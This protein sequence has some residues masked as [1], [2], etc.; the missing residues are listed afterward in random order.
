MSA[1]RR[2]A[3][4]LLPEHATEI[5]KA[6][7]PYDLWISILMWFNAAYNAA[8]PGRIVKRIYEYLWWTRRQPRQ[9]SADS[10]LYTA[11]AC[12]FVEHIPDHP[13]ARL[14]M[15]RWWTRASVLE[16]ADVFRYWLGDDGLT[17]LLQ[18]V[19]PDE[20]GDELKRPRAKGSSQHKLRRLTRPT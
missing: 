7:N 8:D 19:F 18:E 10:D 17:A 9:S 1:W 6:E 2:E 13:K 14:D 4:R 11:A 12:C 3:I 16:H 5:R 15:P 20:R